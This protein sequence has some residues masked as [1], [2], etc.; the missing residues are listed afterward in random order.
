MF[1]P[2]LLRRPSGVLALQVIPGSRRQAGP[3][4]FR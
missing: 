2:N 3:N 1:P 4:D